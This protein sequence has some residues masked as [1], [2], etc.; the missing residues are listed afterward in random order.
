[1]AFPAR[2]S[3]HGATLRALTRRK[4]GRT[5]EN[6]FASGAGTYQHG[7]QVTLTA[8]ALTGNAFSGWSGSGI[9]E[10]NASSITLTLT[11]DLNVTA[12][13]VQ[14]PNKLNDSIS[15]TE[16]IASWYVSN[17]LG[18]FYQADNGW[19]YHFNLGWIYPQPQSDGSLWIWSP[20]LEWIWLEQGT[21]SN[22]FIWS[23]D[24]NNWLYFDFSSATGPRIYKYLTGAWSAFDRDKAIDP[25]DSVF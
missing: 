24:D 23:G 17:W 12:T 13:F 25:L 10:S 4:R 21:F 1:M 8:S 7:S 9:S 5:C 14:L 16:A 15:A 22:A 2:S 6:A 20:Q 11:Q 19:C 18:Y 3:T